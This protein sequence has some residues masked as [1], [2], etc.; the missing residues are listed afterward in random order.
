MSTGPFHWVA[1][2]RLAAQD[3]PRTTGAGRSD[4]PD[5]PAPVHAQV[6]PHRDAALEAEEQ[7]LPDRLDALEPAPVDRLRDAGDEPARMRGRRRQ[8]EPDE[9]VEPRCGAMEGVAFG[10]PGRVK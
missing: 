3:E 8:A 6:A 2:M 9:R 5:A 10:H 7:V 1:S 4:R